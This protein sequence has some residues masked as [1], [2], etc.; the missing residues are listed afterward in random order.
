VG[1]GAEH[2]AQIAAEELELDSKISGLTFQIR[3][4]PVD[5]YGANA[6]GLP[7]LPE[8]FESRGR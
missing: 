8:C 1:Q 4:S 7:M 2:L 3:S 5:L 6:T